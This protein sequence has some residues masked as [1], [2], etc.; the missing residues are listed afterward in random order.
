MTRPVPILYVANAADNGGGNRV[1]IDIVSGLNRDRFAPLVVTPAP[2]P[3]EE[4]A[5]DHRID[6]EVI[7]DGDWTDKPRLLY[8]TAA[9]V[10]LGRVFGVGLVHAMAPACYRA[11]GLAGR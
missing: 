7:P 4:C 5:V 3:L 10:R 1:L 2:G 6:V 11:A 9:M 8:R